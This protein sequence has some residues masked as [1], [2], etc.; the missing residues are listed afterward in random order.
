MVRD[1]RDR[2]RE[3]DRQ[4]QRAEEEKAL[5]Q[6]RY[7]QRRAIVFGAGGV[8]LAALVVLFF[9]MYRHANEQATLA[10]SGR[11]AASAVL[12]KDAALDLAS[13][14]GVEARRLADTFETRNAA[15]VTFQTNPRLITYLHHSV[16]VQSVAISP[17]RRSEHR[18]LQPGWEDAR[19]RQ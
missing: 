3:L 17:P 10:T 4:R 18:L 16:S 2:R 5:A 12:T 9:L 15:L 19:V 1:H 6:A 11:L 14:L 8:G 13:L 7:R